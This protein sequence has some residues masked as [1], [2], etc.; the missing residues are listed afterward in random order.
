MPEEGVERARGADEQEE[1]RDARE[2]HYDHLRWRGT[3]HFP[4]RGTRQPLA[5][6]QRPQ[7]GGAEAAPSSGTNRKRKGSFQQ[8]ELPFFH[9]VG[10]QEENIFQQMPTDRRR[11]RLRR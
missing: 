2:P 9:A 4:S 3:S 1:E 6:P 7:P 8:W 11:R 10:A 5:P